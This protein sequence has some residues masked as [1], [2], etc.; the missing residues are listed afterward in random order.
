MQNLAEFGQ[1]VL[2]VAELFK[3]IL[4]I[5]SFRFRNT[6]LLFLAQDGAKWCQMVPHWMMQNL[7]EYGQIV[8]IVAELFKMI[9]PVY[10][11][12]VFLF[13]W[14]WMIFVDG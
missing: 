1:I 11:C 12:L 8:L 10:D 14:W 6:S 9:F 4:S 13:V 7:A 5:I 3:M 2:M